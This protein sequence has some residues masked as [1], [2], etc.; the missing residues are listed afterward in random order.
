MA[1]DQVTGTFGNEKVTLN[2]AATEATLRQLL[3]HFEK[4]SGSDTQAKDKLKKL[5]ESAK[6]S[7]EYL[8]DWTKKLKRSENRFTRGLGHTAEAAYGLTK[9]FIDGSTSLGEF[10]NHLTGLIRQVPIVGGVFGET[11]QAFVNVVDGQ[12]EVFRGLSS[13]GVTFG[14][15]LF[16]T[17]SASTRANLA[18][19]TFTGVI[20][21]SATSLAVLEGS[22][23]RGARTFRDVSAQVQENARNFAAL[24]LTV[25]ETAEFQADFLDIQTRLGQAQERNA[26]VLGRQTVDYINNLDELSRLTGRQRD[27]ISKSL[28]QE[29]LDRRIS[30][31]LTTL[32]PEARRQLQ[33]ITQTLEARSP[34]V[35]EAFREM[36]ATGGVPLSEFGQDLLRTNS[37][38]GEMARGLRDG[39]VSAEQVMAEFRRT[40]DIAN[41]MGDSQMRLFATTAA[42]GNT[43]GAAVLEMRG[44]TNIGEGLNEVQ[45]ERLDAE[46]KGA[47]ALL[48]FDAALLQTRNEIIGRLVDSG[49]FR[50]LENLLSRV[51]GVFTSGETMKALESG[52]KGLSSWLNGL[53]SDIESGNLWET[54]SSYAADAMRK[55]GSFLVGALK[56][57]LFGREASAADVKT[58]DELQGRQ[59]DLQ[60]KMGPGPH[61][62]ISVEE[63]KELQAINRELERIDS[64]DYEGILSGLFDFNWQSLAKIGIWAA[65]FAAGLGLI[66][67]GLSALGAKS[68][69]ILAGGAAIG[70]A[71]LAIGAGIAGAT[72]LMGGALTKFA[73][74]L[75]LF[76]EIDGGNLFKIGGG[77]ISLGGG[78]AVFSAG[79]AALAVGNVIDSV[80][81]FFTK[82][83]FEKIAQELK[84]FDSIDLSTVEQ[85]TD[86][87]DGLLGLAD[88]TDK[89]DA[90]PIAGYTDAIVDL[91]DALKDM[92][93]ELA[94]SSGGGILGRRSTPAAG[95]IL[96]NITSAGSADS[97][98]DQKLEE[99]NRTLVDIL[100]VLMRTHDI[101]RRQLNA[102]RAMTNNLYAGS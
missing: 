14:D 31:L 26:T 18:L 71:I 52:I 22:A 81:S 102:T 74:G 75:Q 60:S 27:E 59:Q 32:E 36:V 9:T 83:P 55:L 39:S 51:V 56:T 47:N 72:W 48:A 11:I 86:T 24:G 63:T 19:S 101:D 10:S 45:Q 99:V 82:S 57:V 42:L 50:S 58:R 76:D 17:L 70:G 93:K 92:N 84:H 97:D 13:V 7:S 98:R 73:E 16:D 87:A 61:N 53:I 46:E 91:T 64:L 43:V 68:P 5:G 89:L 69:L 100:G 38:L 62:F 49:I 1:R 6:N 40:A 95:E 15:S 66:G 29:T 20:S 44:F 8:K 65:G 35:A 37:R 28:Q 3:N 85:I 80:L 21:S 41:N 12:I 25:E 30:A 78:M 34:E 94:G 67:A 96:E 88:I 77:L 33:T 2:N 54:L 79:M 4:V 90:S 23:N